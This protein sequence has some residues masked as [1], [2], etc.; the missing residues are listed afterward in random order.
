MS[1]IQHMLSRPELVV[2]NWIP[3]GVE[4]RR[5]KT[6]HRWTSDPQ[7]VGSRQPGSAATRRRRRVALQRQGGECR[8]GCEGDV[9][10][11]V[12]WGA[13]V[14]VGVGGEDDD[15]GDAEGGE[16]GG[17]G[18]AGVGAEVDV[19]EGDVHRGAPGDGEG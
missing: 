9:G 12:V 19:D 4:I 10:G 18:P 15:A 2:Q 13:V 1:G 5:R 7:V 14:G 6:A 8:L 3:L 16:G 17:E 11:E